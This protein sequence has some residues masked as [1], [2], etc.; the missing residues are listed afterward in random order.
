M[1]EG[2]TSHGR[3]R[4]EEPAPPPR[5]NL[6]GRDIKRGDPEW[7]TFAPSL[8]D[9]IEFCLRG[10]SVQCEEEHWAAMLVTATLRMPNGGL[11][12]TGSYLGC[13]SA[14]KAPEVASLVKEGRVH[15]CCEDPCNEDVAGLSSLPVLHVGMVRMWSL[16]NFEAAYLSREGK[17]ILTKAK[18][19]D[20]GE[21]PREREPAKSSK[22]RTSRR[23]P[24]LKRPPLGR[25][26][27]PVKQE[28]PRRRKRAAPG[29]IAI[30][31]EEE[32][33][34]EDEEGLMG[35][36]SGVRPPLSQMLR[37][38]RER[39]A[40]GDRRFAEVQRDKRRPR[41]AGPEEDPMMELYGEAL[42][43][44]AAPR[45]S[46]RAPDKLKTGTFLNPAFATPLAL[47]D[48]EDTNE[49]GMITLRKREKSKKNDPA[50]LLLAQA[51]QQS[52]AKTSKSSSTKKATTLVRALRKVFGKKDESGRRN[53]RGGEAKKLSVK[54]EDPDPDDEDDG[55]EGEE[56]S[57]SKESDSE[58]S[59]EAPLR[60]KASKS[61]G[62]VM[63][64]LVRHA[65]EQ[66]DRG[67]LG[68][69]PG[70]RGQALVDG[71]KIG[72]YFALLIRPYYAAGNPLLRELYSLAQTID[73]LRGGRLSEAA[74]ALAGRFISVHTALAEGSWATA[75]HLELFPLEPVAS[76]ST[77]TMLQAQRHKRL[78]QKSQGYQPRY[79]PDQGGRGRGSYGGE[80]GRKGDSFNKGKNKG[81]GK[82][83]TEPWGKK[84]ENPWKGNKEEPPKEK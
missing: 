40:A 7:T 17:S 42:A 56:S 6:Y 63:N 37:E 54:R 38:T 19:R 78:V 47:A 27:N 77:S 52:K 22:P 72:T 13:E 34:E 35:G 29:P 60:K 16:G 84:G 8:Q 9:I 83:A 49:R 36:G 11:I 66:L 5:L 31:S 68:E 55:D 28:Q 74:D 14:L 80:K 45:P 44:G 65:Q 48:R 64:M 59:L 20:E 3:E 61:P 70:R 32:E 23:A 53:R 18:K 62:S 69:D 26:R 46:K 57:G 82:G 39:I 15:L 4:G 1:V 41:R 30:S 33:V 58:L 51:V 21:V 71:V 73:L 50:A 43:G 81:R 24:A 12:L 79:W 67:S 76:T 10:S 75:A 2:D 25:G